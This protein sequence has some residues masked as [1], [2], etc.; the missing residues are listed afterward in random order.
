MFGKTRETSA[1][2]SAVGAGLRPALT[3]EITANLQQLAKGILSSAVYVG[4]G[5]LANQAG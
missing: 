3:R 5:R 4:E 1:S 2:E